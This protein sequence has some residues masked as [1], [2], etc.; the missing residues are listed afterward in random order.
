[1]GT[2]VVSFAA[3]Q[4]LGFVKDKAV[5]EA[6]GL[7]VGGASIGAWLEQA[8]LGILL[9]RGLRPEP[10]LEQTVN[11]KFAEVDR[12]IAEI[13]V[14]IEQLTQ[15]VSQFK[16]DVDSALREQ[17]EKD[18][19]REIFQVEADCDATF[20]AIRDLGLSKSPL[21]V[22]VQSA[23]ELTNSIRLTSTK[24]ANMENCR[25]F[26]LGRDSGVGKR[27]PGFFEIWGDQALREIDLKGAERTLPAY[28]TLE[29]KFIRVLLIQAKCARLLAEAHEANHQRVPT[30]IGAAEFYAKKFYPILAEEVAAFRSMI[31]TLA[32]NLLPL[33]S[34]DFFPF[35]ISQEIADMLAAVDL[36][37]GRL[38]SGRIDNTPVKT[39]PATFFLAGC[40][41][42]II[43]PGTRWIRRPA[44]TQEQA[45]I[46]ISGAG[47]EVTCRGQ[48]EIR[49]VN[50][51][52]YKDSAG[53]TRHQG[54]QLRVGDQLRDFDSMLMVEFIPSEAIAQ[55]PVSDSGGRIGVTL[56]TA[57]GTV[58]ARATGAVTNLTLDTERQLRVP[59]GAFVA[60]FSG[61]ATVIGK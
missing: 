53:K 19:F 39:V 58:L 33:P 14:K 11:L 60:A 45:A 34:T 27:L 5:S 30:E 18:L 57:S 21:E 46:A 29:N 48:I 23:L 52:P 47:L 61:G 54:Y 9:G 44:G 35:R 20:S 26:M 2:V 55:G 43:V 4:I 13:R 31:E 28:R 51:R 8:P 32:V 22:R 3:E 1:M 56:S 41:G 37:A 15:E 7:E 24:A 40:W 17:D 59:F 25:S 6:L 12:Q 49:T 36:L 16:F 10:T 42:R 38:L 50:F